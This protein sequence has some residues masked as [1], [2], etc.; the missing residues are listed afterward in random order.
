MKILKDEEFDIDKLFIYFNDLPDDEFDICHIYKTM[1]VSLLGNME[2]KDEFK[3]ILP[4][5]DQEICV[6][7]E[8]KKNILKTINYFIKH[9]YRFEI[10]EFIR[11]FMEIKDYYENEY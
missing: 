6:H 5:N 11:E 3:F 4:L 10:Y 7:L 9:F 2:N 8:N 1:I